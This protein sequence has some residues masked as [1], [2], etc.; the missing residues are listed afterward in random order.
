MGI[1][2]GSGGRPSRVLEAI[3]RDHPIVLHGVSLS[4]GSTDPLDSRYL[5]RLRLLSDRIEPAWLS[6]H[7]CW[8]GVGGENLHD[9]LPLPFTAEALDHLVARILKAQVSLGPAHSA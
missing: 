3:R 6:D 8:T 2:S 7:L 1:G 5:K 4:I 9:L